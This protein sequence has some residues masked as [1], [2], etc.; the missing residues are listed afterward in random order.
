MQ[1]TLPE[2]P[3]IHQPGNSLNIILWGFFME[4]L[5]QRH[6]RSLTPFLALLTSQDNQGWG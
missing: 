6:D 1:G 5:S 4:A 2:A 3:R